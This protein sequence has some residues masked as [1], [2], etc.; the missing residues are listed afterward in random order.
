MMALSLSCKHNEKCVFIIMSNW[1]LKS[2][3]PSNESL[4]NKMHIEKN[5]N[6]FFNFWNF[7]M[8]FYMIYSSFHIEIL[9]LSHDVLDQL[10]V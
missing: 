4:K 5:L 2:T 6:I 8:P 1:K 9:K 7:K 3:P 10:H